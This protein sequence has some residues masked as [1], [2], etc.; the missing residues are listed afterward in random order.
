[1]IQRPIELFGQN[2]SLPCPNTL[3]W[4]MLRN[5]TNDIPYKDFPC[6]F[7][8]DKCNKI[9]KA[10][11]NPLIGNCSVKLS[12][13][14]RDEDW[15]VCPSRFV[16]NDVIFKD[17]MYL[18]KNEENVK[19]TKEIHLRNSGN[20][21]YALFSMNEDDD[22]VVD[23]LGVEVQGMGTSSSG[24]IWTARNDYLNGEF[25]E[26]YSFSLNEKDAS[27]KILVQL[28]HKG[29]QLSRWRFRLVLIIQDYFLEHL[30]SVY[31]LDAHFHAASTQD[32]IYIHSYSL[33]LNE[34]S[35][36]Y[37]MQLKE[38]LS[39]D[40]MG[41]SMALI[42][43]PNKEYLEFTEIQQRLITRTQEGRCPHLVL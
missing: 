25:R 24:P 6:P 21:D 13:N 43:N 14:N 1:M 35:Q 27:K 10:A 15:I 29:A 39:T 40:V 20:L 16:Q 30:K 32:F 8:G 11:P 2:T 18:M 41:L 23:F 19:V 28:L 3:H 31:N 26:R 12:S 7:S 4:E 5:E 37:E 34:E 9:R 17:S 22:R 38:K 33:V 42:S 36:Q